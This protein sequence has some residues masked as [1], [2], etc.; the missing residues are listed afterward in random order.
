MSQ[1]RKIRSQFAATR[2]VVAEKVFSSIPFLL[3][4]LSRDET[5]GP[6]YRSDESEC[7]LARAR[8]GGK[9]EKPRDEQ[10]A[11][12]TRA[13]PR[14]KDAVLPRR[15]NDEDINISVSVFNESYTKRTRDDETKANKTEK[16]IFPREV[17]SCARCEKGE[18][19]LALINDN[20][21]CRS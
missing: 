11:Q 9:E 19:S 4:T 3:S 14:S 16:K 21:Y 17:A 8:K 7:L 6:E 2:S 12:L 10:R 5:D 15:E 13:D 1:F 20:R 18:F